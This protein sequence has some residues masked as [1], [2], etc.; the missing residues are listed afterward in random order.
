MD[1]TY[2]MIPNGIASQWNTL[3]HLAYISRAIDE[4]KHEVEW[5][6]I[7]YMCL[8][9]IDVG[10]SFDISITS[11]QKNHLSS[12]QGQG[13][14]NIHSNAHVPLIPLTDIFQKFGL[15]IGE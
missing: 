12:F 13:R 10:S 1:R 7:S 15:K 3:L 2:G 4:F 8:G 14:S 6:K 5:N 9:S 11:Y